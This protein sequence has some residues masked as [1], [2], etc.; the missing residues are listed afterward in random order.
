MIYLTVVNLAE[1]R[2]RTKPLIVCVLIAAV[3]F[4][5]EILPVAMQYPKQAV[6]Q[7][8]SHQSIREALDEIPDDASVTASTFYTT[9]LS[10]RD[11]IYDLGYASKRHILES[12]YVVL[13]PGHDAD[14]ETLTAILERNGYIR[15]ES[16]D[17]PIL[18]YR[19]SLA[20]N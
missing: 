19:K 2:V 20:K 7:W 10:Q 12:E 18:I 14:W 15:S 8:E 11:V 4:G 6:L 16:E 9:Y 1:L 5:S 17:I 3:C 13:D